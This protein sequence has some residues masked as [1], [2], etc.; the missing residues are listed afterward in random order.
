MFF[1]GGGFS[2]SFFLSSESFYISYIYIY[3]YRCIGTEILDVYVVLLD[4]ILVMCELNI[5]RKYRWIL[6]N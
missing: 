6:P 2:G 5:C 1:F 4:W 3:V